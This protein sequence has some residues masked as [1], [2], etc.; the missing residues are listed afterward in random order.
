M[1][2]TPTERSWPDFPRLPHCQSF[3]FAQY[4]DQGSLDRLMKGRLPPS[5]MDLLRG[6]LTFDPERRLTAAEALQHPF[7][8]ESPLP[9]HPSMFP[10]WPSKSDKIPASTPHAPKGHQTDS[11]ID[12]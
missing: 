3:Q 10:S 5:G 8:T 12:T 9:K 6:L 11:S 4:R 7:F 2:G 1:L